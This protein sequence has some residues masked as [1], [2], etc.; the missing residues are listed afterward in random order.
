MTLELD[1]QWVI[2][3]AAVGTL[4]VAVIGGAKAICVRLNAVTAM[5]G[6]LDK[7]QGELGRM[8]ERLDGVFTI[9]AKWDHD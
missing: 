1:P 3:I 7:M 6:A 4:T 2:A 9:L 8:D 5:Q